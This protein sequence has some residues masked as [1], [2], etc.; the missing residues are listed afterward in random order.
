MNNLLRLDDN[1]F[2]EL[3]IYNDIT[4]D[5]I[6]DFEIKAENELKIKKNSLNIFSFG[7]NENICNTNLGI[8]KNNPLYTLDVNGTLNYTGDIYLNGLK[9]VDFVKNGSDIYYN[10]GN[11]GFN[12]TNPTELL[13]IKDTDCVMSI[14]NRDNSVGQSS[15]FKIGNLLNY[16]TFKSTSLIGDENDLTLTIGDDFSSQSILKLNS[17]KSIETYGDLNVGN[18]LRTDTSVNRVTINNSSSTSYDGLLKIGNS[19]FTDTELIRFR[20][21]RNWIFK[22]VG[23]D[24]SSE[25]YLSSTTSGTKNFNIKTNSQTLLQVTATDTA[26]D[27]RVIMCANGGKVTMGSGVSG[28]E[29]L[30]VNGN[31]KATGWI[32]SDLS[33]SF[34]NMRVHR[35]TGNVTINAGLSYTSVYFFNYT[36]VNAYSYFLVYVDGRYYVDGGG[37]DNVF[38]RIYK[39]NVATIGYHRSNWVAQGGG[40]GRGAPLLPLMTIFDNINNLNSVKIELRCFTQNTDDRVRFIAGNGLAHIIRVIEYKY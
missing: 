13:H 14:L 23:I 1:I 27:Q 2:E 31:V 29:A 21:E 4:L 12:T 39:N 28:N 35:L 38:L 8:N 15:L 24:S 11:V 34:L 25:L 33:G 10:D 5:N 36:P 9:Q 3:T 17:D 22:G 16:Y 18:V 6:K 19:S 30:N 20:S 37:G 40:G 26:A 32:R 7:E